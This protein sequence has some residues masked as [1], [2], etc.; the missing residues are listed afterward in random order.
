MSAPKKLLFVINNPDF[1]VSHRLPLATAARE[2][3]MDVAIAAPERTGADTLR[4]LGFRFHPVPLTR[5]TAQ[6]LEEA[7]AVWSLLRLFQ[8]ERPDVVHLVTIKP[9]L[10][11]GVAARLAKVP[12]VVGALSG[13]GYVFIAEGARARARR[14]LVEA[15]YR[16][17]FVHPNLRVIFQNPDDRAQFI[18]RGLLRASD[19]VL[20]RGSGVD[21]SQFRPEPEPPTDERGKVVLLASRLLFDKGVGELVAASRLLRARGVTAR[22]V[23]AGEVDPGNPSSVTQAELDGWV[24][25][26]VVEWWGQR[27]D[28]PQ[29]FA[30]SHLV[31]L[32]SYREG[33]P[34][35]LVE[36]AACGRAILTSDVPGCR[37]VVRH[38]DNGL[39]VPP[40]NAPALADAVASLLADDARRQR[41]G[42]RGRERA[43]AEFSLEGVVR[44]TLALY[45][46]V[47]GC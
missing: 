13:L 3:G 4:K 25:E 22:F 11:G 24:R 2:A 26:G 15:A 32:P 29:V 36:A 16:L 40:R 43:E 7:R 44:D 27:G 10:Y 1:F 46:L 39:L 41:M 14:R 45:G 42:A 18:S 33:L 5:R 6:P 9:V 34:R 35:V 20:I 12:R 37:E 19:A 38:G 31:C 8:R 30:R 21:L 23:L 17:A 28:M 47:A